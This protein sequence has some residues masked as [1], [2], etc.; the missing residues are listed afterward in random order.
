M[1]DLQFY[2]KNLCFSLDSILNIRRMVFTFHQPYY[3]NRI[4]GV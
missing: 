2:I 4:K 1:V 3:E